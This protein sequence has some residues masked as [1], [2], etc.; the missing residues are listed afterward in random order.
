VQAGGSGKE[1]TIMMDFLSMDNFPLWED[2]NNFSE[3][4]AQRKMVEE[5]VQAHAEKMTRRGLSCII[6]E[7][8]DSAETSTLWVCSFRRRNG[9]PT[10][11]WRGLVD[12]STEG[13]LYTVR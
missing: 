9:P 4:L 3:A 8:R 7:E 5:T 12:F 13:H 11:E 6:V 2:P 10:I 1:E